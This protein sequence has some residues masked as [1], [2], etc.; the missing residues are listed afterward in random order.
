MATLNPASGRQP[1]SSLFPSAVEIA[2]HLRRIGI[3]TADPTAPAEWALPGTTAEPFSMTFVE[4]QLL[5]WR[6]HVHAIPTIPD[7]QNKFTAR[8]PD[9]PEVEDLWAAAATYATPGDRLRAARCMLGWSQVVLASETKQGSSTELNLLERNHKRSIG[10]LDAMCTAVHAPIPWVRDGLQACMPSWLT[11]WRHATI[12]ADSLCEQLV[13]SCTLGYQDLV[14]GKRSDRVFAGWM[15][16]PGDVKPQEQDWWTSAGSLLPWF[17]AASSR[18]WMGNTTEEHLKM[19]E[20]ARRDLEAIVVDWC[21]LQT[22]IASVPGL[23]KRI[24]T[25]GRSLQVADGERLAD[26]FAK[27]R[28]PGQPLDVGGV[29]PIDAAIDALGQ[30][31]VQPDWYLRGVKQLPNR[32]ELTLAR[33]P[34]QAKPKSKRGTNKQG[35]HPTEP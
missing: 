6:K 1:E 14:L 20:R 10:G 23:A 8:A 7:A 5:G 15:R 29:P 9:V 17:P 31:A 28:T 3:P 12:E 27:A 30:A 32:M 22:A 13:K 21:I 26:F 33:Q 35:S 19:T 16:N 34:V 18:F 4:D 11:P 25:K 2:A 24:R